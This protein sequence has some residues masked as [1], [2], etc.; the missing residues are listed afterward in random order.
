ML[1]KRS[2]FKIGV[3]R[4][5]W[6]MLC[7]R[8]IFSKVCRF[9]PQGVIRGGGDDTIRRCWWQ[10]SEVSSPVIVVVDISGGGNLTSSHSLQFILTELHLLTE[11]SLVGPTFHKRTSCTTWVSCTHHATP[12]YRSA[13]GSGYFQTLRHHSLVRLPEQDGWGNRY[14]TAVW[15]VLQWVVWLRGKYKMFWGKSQG[16]ENK[17]YQDFSYYIYFDATGLNLNG[18]SWKRWQFSVGIVKLGCYKTEKYQHKGNL[19]IERIY[20]VNI[21]FLVFLS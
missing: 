9:N 14:S 8:C 20:P 6:N 2:I 5:G 13:R 3:H 15:H 16:D 11:S 21:F 4:R 1:Y 18:N 19:Y 10:R 12:H 7:S 17:Y